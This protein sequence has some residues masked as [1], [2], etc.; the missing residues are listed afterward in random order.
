MTSTS[1]AQ[2]FALDMTEAKS[3][4]SGALVLRHTRALSALRAVWASR[5]SCQDA[6][7]AKRAQHAETLGYLERAYD[8]IAKLERETAALRNDLA[9]KGSDFDAACR[10]L[11]E[12]RAQFALLFDALAEHGASFTTEH[13][14]VVAV[15]MPP[16]RARVAELE[17]ERD[18]SRA[19]AGWAHGHAGALHARVMELR[20]QVTARDK[21]IAELEAGR[22]KIAEILARHRGTSTRNMRTG[23][24]KNPVREGYDRGLTKALALLGVDAREADVA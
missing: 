6:L 1:E 3:L 22:D 4:P 12:V 9:A 5:R 16:H 14:K 7:K 19:D 2:R 10:H 21:R 23:E 18:E 17:A 15:S 24:Y 13:G 20:S 8:E 11:G